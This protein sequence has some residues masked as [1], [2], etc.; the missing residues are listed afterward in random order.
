MTDNMPRILTL[1]VFVGVVFLTLFLFWILA[2]NLFYQDHDAELYSELLAQRYKLQEQLLLMPKE[3]A[4]KIPDQQFDDYG[5]A[6]DALLPPAAHNGNYDESVAWIIVPTDGIPHTGSGFFISPHTLVTNAHVVE[7]VNL[8][9]LIYVAMQDGGIV[10]A[11][12]V[13]IGNSQIG[14]LDLAVLKLAEN[15]YSGKPMPI[16]VLKAEFRHAIDPCHS[17]RLSRCDTTQYG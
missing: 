10:P 9:E 15:H 4:C 8:Q 14:D 11:N 12:T 16:N 6:P 17:F 5:K 7:K 1:G 2:G 3:V 13:A